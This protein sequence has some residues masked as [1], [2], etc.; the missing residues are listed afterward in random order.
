MNKF[1]KHYGL[2]LLLLILLACSG[3]VLA[4]PQEVGRILMATTGV[5]AQQPGQAQRELARRSPVFVG[6]TLR[7]PEGGRAQLRMADGEMI[8]L[9]ANSQLVIEAFKH[10]PDAPAADD[11]SVKRLVTGGLRTI[12]GA[13]GGEGYRVES[14]AGTIGIRG[15]AFEVFSEQGNNLFVRTQRGNI[16]VQN[17]FGR[18]EIGVD[19]PQRAAQ[20]LS[21]NQPPVAIPQRD[22]PDFFDNAFEE[23]VTLGL[24]GEQEEQ[25]ADRVETPVPRTPGPMLASLLTGDTE[26]YAGLVAVISPGPYGFVVGGGYGGAFFSSSITSTENQV[27]GSGGTDIFNLQSVNSFDLWVESREPRLIGDSQ[28]EWGNW[29][30]G[31][32]NGQQEENFSFAWVTATQVHT[33]LATLPSVGSY[34]YTL[35]SSGYIVDGTLDVNF[36]TGSIDV[37]LQEDGGEWKGL[38]TVRQFYGSGIQLTSGD[39]SGMITGRF[40]GSNAEGAIAAYDLAGEQGIAVFDRTESGAA[41]GP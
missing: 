6:D 30:T 40:V 37:F 33:T 35:V 31:T 25:P 19:M 36:L 9:T 13:V 41:T 8:S 3:S 17:R 2:T 27:S 1:Y 7:T 18:V 21:V 4:Q 12:T 39:G 10:Q 11:A 14:R 23:D 20:I 24:A 5:T 29:A 16:Y 15:T 38:G 28:V 32:I 34:E 26:N 22:L